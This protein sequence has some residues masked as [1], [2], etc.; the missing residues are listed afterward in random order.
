[1]RSFG[2]VWLLIA[3]AAITSSA[4]ERRSCGMTDC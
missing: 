1:M 3:R 2:A 4:R